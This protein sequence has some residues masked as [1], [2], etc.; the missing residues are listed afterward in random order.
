M[1]YN[2]KY[3]GNDLASRVLFFSLYTNFYVILWVLL[4]IEKM[5]LQYA[6]YECIHLNILFLQFWETKNS[7]FFSTITAA[8][9]SETYSSLNLR[10]GCPLKTIICFT[11]GYWLKNERYS[12]NLTKWLFS[13]NVLIFLTYSCFYVNWSNELYC[14]NLKWLLRLPKCTF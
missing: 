8:I 11:W 4:Y 7:A 6:R 13:L 14:F 1:A 3:S 12:S 9:L 5:Y 10:K 2:C